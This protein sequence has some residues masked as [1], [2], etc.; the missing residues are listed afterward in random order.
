MS[1]PSSKNMGDNAWL[2]KIETKWEE[3]REIKEG[4]KIKKA[5][6]EQV[7]TVEEECVFQPYYN[8]LTP[9]EIE[10]F[11]MIELAHIQNKYLTREKYFVARAY[12]R[13]QGHYPQV[14]ASLM[15]DVRHYIINNSIITTS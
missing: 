9:T 2:M 5:A 11:K 15:L 8:H 7:P 6:E 3:I 1:S 12:H 14:G 10:A 4:D 13:T